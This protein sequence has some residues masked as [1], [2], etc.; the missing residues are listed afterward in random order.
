M[1]SK[2]PEIGIVSLGCPKALVD[3]E[4]IVTRLRSEGYKISTTYENADVVL[5]NTCGFL[6]SAKEESLEA[7]GEA[8]SKNGQVIVTGCMGKN[9]AMIRAAHPK[10]SAVTGPQKFEEVMEAVH[11][12]VPPIHNPY[13][14]IIPPQGI[15]LTPRHYA[16]VKIAEGCNH[17]CSFC[18]IPQLRG[19][20]KSRQIGEILKEAEHLV[21][22]GVKELL[23]ISQDTGAYGSDLKFRESLWKN[24]SI[25]TKMIDLFEALGDFGVWVRAHYVYPYPHIDE[26]IPLMAD[27]KILPYLDIPFQHGSPKI[28]KAMNRP[29]QHLAVL[30]R[31][32]KWREIC[33]DLTIRSTFIV[34]FPGETEEDFLNLLNWLKEAR[35]DRVGCFKYEEVE[36]ARSNSLDNLLSEDLKQERWE[37]LM[38]VQKEI[39]RNLL[40]AKI[41]QTLE[42]M[43]DEVGAQGAIGRSH[44]DAPE[45]DG[46]VFL[47][48]DFKAKPGDVFRAKIKKATEYDLWASR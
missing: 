36:G 14:D 29:A 46:K 22:A 21:A 32:A 11:K 23:I 1:Q 42:V 16:Y 20:L 47:K 26:L 38:A 30:D 48:G 9:E 2:I 12:I 44:A 34:G 13:T 45:I 43:V 18:I 25:K 39:S 17:R 19:K 24:K 3:T 8:I 33:P 35:L 27:G 37:R 31:I 10:V 4:R 41:G 7:I 15:K 28:L 5:V 40:H 6:N